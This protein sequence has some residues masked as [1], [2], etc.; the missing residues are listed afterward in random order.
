MWCWMVSFP[1]FSLLM[2]SACVFWCHHCRHCQ[3]NKVWDTVC[4]SKLIYWKPMQNFLLRDSGPEEASKRQS[5]W[6]FWMF[7]EPK[8]AN[9]LRY[10]NCCTSI[11][12]KKQLSSKSAKSAWRLL[13]FR[14]LMTSHGF[15]GLYKTLQGVYPIPC[16]KYWSEE[17]FWT[18]SL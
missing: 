1:L 17:G 7:S 2:H 18:P 12:F 11:C 16:M 9:S 5:S 14:P 6:R 15:S 4:L 10:A 3:N 8:G 13:R